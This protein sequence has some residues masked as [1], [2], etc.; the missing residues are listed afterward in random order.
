MLK[1][2]IEHMT[3]A[4][5]DEPDRVFVTESQTGVDVYLELH[6]APNDMG[7]VIGRNGKVANALRTLVQVSAAR[8]AKRAQLEIAESV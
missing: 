8:E 2:L 5:V 6:V 4:I 3:R 7:R 1:H